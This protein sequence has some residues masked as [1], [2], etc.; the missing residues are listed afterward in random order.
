MNNEIRM[1]LTDIT[2]GICNRNTPRAIKMEVLQESINFNRYNFLG[3]DANGSVV[4][5]MPKF[6]NIR[7]KKGRFACRRGK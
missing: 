3:F 4:R 2:C 7:D 6:H 5:L 1:N